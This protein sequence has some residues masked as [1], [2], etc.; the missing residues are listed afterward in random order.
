MNPATPQRPVPPRELDPLD[1]LPGP[2][3]PT[4]RATLSEHEP[5]RRDEQLD[6]PYSPFPEAQMGRS[7]G[8][9]GGI[10]DARGSYATLGG[11][12]YLRGGGGRAADAEPGM[13][14][15]DHRGR[16]PRR[17]P[18]SD[19]RLE[20]ALN[21]RLTEHPGID[22][23]G[24]WIECRERRVTLRGLVPE[25]QMKYLAEDLTASIDGVVDVDN[26][27]EVRQSSG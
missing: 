15:M 2:I 8:G 27:L 25:R 14:R 11:D 3:D 4:L 5:L 9:P 20:E 23:S 12:D 6:A 26:R 16:G 13:T 21:E 7:F 17:P 10:R 19:A 1:E 18:P 22:A 24:I